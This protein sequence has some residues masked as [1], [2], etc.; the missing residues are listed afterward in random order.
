MIAK[1]NYNYK[2]RILGAAFCVIISFIIIKSEYSI[3]LNAIQIFS[4]YVVSN[5]EDFIAGG[6]CRKK[7]IIQGILTT[8]IIMIIVH[9]LYLS[10]L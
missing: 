5:I 10:G 8:I 7:S 6:E 4:L 3:I 1:Y 9:I 2:Y